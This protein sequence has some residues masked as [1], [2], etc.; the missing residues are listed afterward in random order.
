VREK[1]AHL[2]GQQGAGR[3]DSRTRQPLLKRAAR[4]LQRPDGQARGI[5]EPN[6]SHPL[7][8]HQI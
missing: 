3:L 7:Q 4:W 6:N 2:A 8:C 1:G 5:Q